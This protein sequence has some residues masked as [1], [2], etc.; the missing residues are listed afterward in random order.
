MK[1][2]IFFILSA[3][4]L[5]LPVFAADTM[6]GTVQDIPTQ[7]LEGFNLSGYSEGG[8]KSWDIKGDK[9]N[10]TGDQVAVTNV[11]ANSYGDQDM[12]MQAK[13]GN[14]DKSTGN[15]NLEDHVVITSESG[16]T[17][18]TN[19]LEWQR[20]KDLVRTNDKVSIED[21]NMTVEGRGLEA[22]PNRKD[23]TLKSD[24]TANVLSDANDKTKDNRIQITS[25][26]PME[27]DQA[28]KSAVFN[29]NVQAVEFSSGRRLKADRMQVIF[30]EDSKKIKE[31]V[32]T[33]NVEVHQGKNITY[34]DNLLYKADEQR[35]VLTGK[36]K[37]LLDPGDRSSKD[38]LKY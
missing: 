28:S 21:K 37:L 27:V 30:D 32:C 10:V 7:E 8:R 6:P 3:F 16:A 15:V 2:I 36:P 22:H 25:D 9:A 12:N 23:A 1:K 18:K 20:G 38:I 19:T 5:S 4:F 24:V 31:I 34:A 35:M 29:N 14:I 33:G 26:G 13:K 11:N 17:L